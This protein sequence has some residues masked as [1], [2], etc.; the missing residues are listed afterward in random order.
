MFKRVLV[1]AAVAA[2]FAAPAFAEVKISGSAELD[3]IFRTNNADVDGGR[4]RFGFEDDLQLAFSGEDKWD[5]GLK[6]IWLVSQKP[7]GG[8]Y[9]P[10]AKAW[11]SREAYIGVAGDGWTVKTGR[12]F[13]DQYLRHDW[14]YLT[15]GS[16]NL[17]EDFGVVGDKVWWTNAIQYNGN[18]GPVN[19]VATYDNGDSAVA[20]GNNGQ[21]YEIG[22]GVDFGAGG[23]F[24]ISYLGLKGNGVDGNN[25]SFFTGVRYPFGPATFFFDFTRNHWGQGGADATTNVYHGKI[26]YAFNDKLSLHGG[27]TYMKDDNDAKATQF[28]VALHYGV[29]KNT[30]AYARVRHI[31]FSKENGTGGYVKPTG[32][33][34]QGLGVD[35]SSKKSGQEFL[36][37][38]W[39]GF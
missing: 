21:G 34:W 37:G 36:I 8:A 18:F 12:M 17:G 2:A 22:G 15:D 6:T 7:G 23:H 9:G 1:A 5:N 27:L 14:P 24:D 35:T 39:T 30:E 16:G 20:G 33:S 10:G 19:V 3:V 13:T 29:G 31:Q 38:T 11:G 28:N 32:M 26:N 25:N 4:N